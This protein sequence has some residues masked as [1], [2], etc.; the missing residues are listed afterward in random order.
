MGRNIILKNQ[1]KGDLEIDQLKEQQ[2]TFLVF[3][4]GWAKMVNRMG[5]ESY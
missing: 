5:R 3:I 4:I 2:Q 1:R